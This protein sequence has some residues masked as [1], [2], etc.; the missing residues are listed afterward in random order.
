[1]R[2]NIAVQ[3]RRFWDAGIR[4]PD[5]LWAATGSALEAFSR[6]PVVFRESAI[7]GKRE[8]MPV[9]AFLRDARRLVVEFAVG[10]VLK[11]DPNAEEDTAGLDDI[12]TYY[13]L[14]R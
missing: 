3:M 13:L 1:M 8:L 2:A 4:G 7:G 11:A 14:H 6:H 10:R 12:T 9:S 5:F